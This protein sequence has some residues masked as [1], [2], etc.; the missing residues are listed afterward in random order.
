MLRKTLVLF[1][2]LSSPFLFSQAF[3]T[4]WV[5]DNPGVSENNQ[6][7][8]PTHPDE[9][10]NYTVDWGDGTF[11]S[12]VTGDIIHT[13][14][15]PGIYRVSI[16]GVF[17]RIYFNGFSNPNAN[18]LLKILSVNQ[19]G[20]IQWSSFESAFEGCSNLDVEANDT[21]D[22][23][24]VQSLR[25]MFTNCESLTGTIA[26]NNWNTANVND[27]NAMFA[28]CTEFNQDIG[29]WN[30]SQVGNLQSMFDGASSFDQNIGDWDVSNVTDMSAMFWEASTFNQFIGNWNVSQVTDMSA[31]FLG[32]IS[33]DQ[34]IS[35]WNVENVIKM[36][37]MFSGAV[38]FDQPIG[39][40]N[41]SNVSN[42]NSM[43]SD[44]TLFNQ[45]LE[46]WDVSNVTEMIN[47]FFGAIN[48]NQPIGNWDVSNVQSLR[49][50]FGNAE[51]FDQSLSDWD[52]SN[53]TD[54]S[55]L[56]FQANSFNQPINNWDV[57]NVLDM[58]RMFSQASNF[59]QPLDNWDTSNVIDTSY[60]FENASFFD[61]AIGGWDVSNVL[62]M[63]S[64]FSNTANFNQNIELWEVSNVTN[65]QNM[66]RNASAFNQPINSW[67]ISNVNNLSGMLAGASLFN[68]SLDNWD[69]SSV[70]DMS[71]LFRAATSFDQ[72]LGNW[73]ISLVGSMIDMFR[74]AGLS[75]ENY[76]NTLI[77]W[78]VLPT[79]QN[80]VQF[81]A[82]TSVY[83]SGES[84]RSKLINDLGWSITDAGKANC[85]FIT[86]WKTDNPGTSADN[87]ITIPTFAGEIYNYT[88]DWGDGTIDTNVTG[89]IT[90]TYNTPGTYEVAITG[91]FPRLYFNYFPEDETKD[92][93]K[94]VS[95]DQWGTIQWASMDNAFARCAN[96]DV[97]ATDIPDLSLVNDMTY[98]F[99]G[100]S[101]LVGNGSFNRWN[102]S[103]VTSMFG[104]FIDT[105]LFNQAIGNWN[106][107]GVTDIGAM[108]LGASAF[109]QDVGSWD[110]SSVTRMVNVFSGAS[111][112]NQDI[113]S[114]GVS[115]VDDMGYMFR[116]ADS[117]NQ[118]ISGWDVSN[119]VR[120][121]GMFLSN[122][123]FNQPLNS[124]DV[125]RVE[126]MAVMFSGATTFNQ[127]LSGWDVSNVFDMD[128]M[129]LNANAFDQDIGSWDISSVTNMT[130]ML[131]G[132]TL[133]IENYDS[134]LMGWSDLPNL[135]PNVTFD[136]G[137]SQYCEA[138]DARQ[139]IIDIYDWT[140][141]DGGETPLCNEDNDAD[142]VSDHKDNCLNSLAGAT[143]D[144]N[145]CDIIP[146]D[147]IR[148]LVLTPS[149]PG[150]SDGAVE[151][152][153][154]ISG[155]LLDIAIEGDEG[156]NQ[157]EDV[158]SGTDFVVNDL[159]IG[160]YTVTLS[161]PE[162]LFEQTYGITVNELGAVSGKR[163]ALDV[164]KRTA[165]YTVSGSKHYTVSVNG[166]TTTFQYATTGEQTI[167]LENLSGQNEIVISGESDCQ[168]K[169]T[170]S[171]FL[172]TSISV[173]P[174]ITSDAFRVITEYEVLD[175][176][177]YSLSGR[178]VQAQQ[179]LEASLQNN[180]VDISTL[181]AGVYLVKM[182][183]TG[184]EERTIKIVKR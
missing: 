111:S 37:L 162:I 132:V 120:M 1:L 121:I 67:N 21:P 125:S 86:T 163:Q 101:S 59:N 26:F 177:I 25:R 23:S 83:C 135:Q 150:G 151:I 65:M 110:V 181:P 70:T 71:F 143:V 99:R 168:G 88:V 93:E 64:M 139:F 123:G 2:V 54:M 46:N 3:I 49:G 154:D 96:M 116:G 39:T 47:T 133:S 124:W 73:D 102:V 19:W 50:M 44:A 45:N 53:V 9:T 24:N 118:D 13:Y 131:F 18:D 113:G 22:L 160:S 175:V 35:N 97:S 15:T 43:F 130:T 182:I 126:D 165:S 122:D 176:G 157:F 155:Y 100:C 75:Q 106:M 72:D 115:K 183:A 173:F 90:H 117:F 137:N 108:F 6:I 55:F 128:S 172:G 56:F 63:E 144:E 167:I 32:A 107:S 33:F 85:P 40:W 146:N 62:N 76:D 170:D 119:V 41:M 82:G 138:G 29:N 161:I 58:N 30:V 36:S 74:F 141:T 79:L 16:T 38:E 42:I 81:N 134:L 57:S 145:G 7:K 31:M 8:I 11:D 105:P 164:G 78:A 87:Q 112:F 153:M 66:F 77:G 14:I 152:V 166:D 142:G 34:D 51:S 61:Q 156:S 5:T 147:A 80:N 28:N 94:I 178:L 171:F 114:W 180:E 103:N 17:P 127:D 12:N 10:Y 109:N 104:V 91:D 60:M 158:P 174:T 84:A 169:I 4:R 136:A 148:I 48:F 92:Y 140:I 69:V 149:C 129:F 95:V 20:E 52:V 27:M 98:M 89:D 179:R 184:S 159:A 68:Q